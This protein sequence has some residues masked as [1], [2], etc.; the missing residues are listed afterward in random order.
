[1]QLDA[2]Q[3]NISEVLP[4]TSLCEEPAR[5]GHVASIEH[6]TRSMG[7]VRA[8]RRGVRSQHVSHIIRW[9]AS[10]GSCAA[11][12]TCVQRNLER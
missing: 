4:L 8:D 10:I 5:L 3:T 11:N 12:E 1:M 7:S 6:F 9:S 2:F